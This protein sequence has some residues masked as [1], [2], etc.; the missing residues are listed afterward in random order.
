MMWCFIFLL[1]MMSSDS[2]VKHLRTEDMMEDLI[3]LQVAVGLG[4]AGSVN[5]VKEV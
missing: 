3:K 1:A 5:F 2:V 4:S